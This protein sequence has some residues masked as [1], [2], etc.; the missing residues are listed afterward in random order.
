MK[1]VGKSKGTLSE[2]DVF[3]LEKEVQHIQHI[4]SSLPAHTN[5]AL[6]VLVAVT[7][8]LEEVVKQYNDKVKDALD[9]K[10]KELS[11]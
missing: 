2:D 7:P 6:D 4:H 8:Q 5:T 9:A 11:K 3:R 1:K 10:L